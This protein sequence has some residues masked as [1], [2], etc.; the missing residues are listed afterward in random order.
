MAEHR[1]PK[2]GVEG[3]NPFTRFCGE[4][5]PIC[6]RTRNVPASL[7]RSS[8]T[9]RWIRV[10]GVLLASFAGATGCVQPEP[11]VG[12]A[13]AREPP[14]RPIGEPVR[15]AKPSEG[16]EHARRPGTPGTWR[17]KVER[18][19]TLFSVAKRF[20][21]TVAD[22]KRLND[23]KNDSLATG[24]ILLVPE[25]PVPEVVEGETFGPPVNGR[26]ASRFGSLRLRA[27][28][29]GVEYAVPAGTPVVASRTGTVVQVSRK[30]PGYGGLVVIRH[31][32]WRTVYGY[33]SE[34][35]VRA[36]RRVRKGTVIGRSGRC[37]YDGAERLHFRIYEGRH[38]R[39]P[40]SLIRK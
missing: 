12:V 7:R 27:T 37:P 36:G 10:L 11:P 15:P 22:L 5:R 26:V 6:V 14:V 38:A 9:A 13:P 19:D 33:M 23:L 29:W 24:Q 3:S 8:A 25:R 1:L 30:F 20:G 17:Y 4:T 39:D 16:T 18:G 32:R 2:P 40:L 28:C 21:T 34:I 31:G 35:G